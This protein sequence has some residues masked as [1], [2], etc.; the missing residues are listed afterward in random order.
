MVWNIN[1]SLAECLSLR[2]FLRVK[3]PKCVPG[4]TAFF[5]KV[6]SRNQVSTIC[7]IF[8]FKMIYKFAVNLWRYNLTILSRRIWYYK[9]STWE[10]SLDSPHARDCLKT[11][12]RSLCK[13][14]ANRKLEARNLEGTG[15][16]FST[17]KV[18]KKII[19]FFSTNMVIF[20]NVNL[21]RKFSFFNWISVERRYLSK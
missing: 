8:E 15:A 9:T 11:D 13:K 12:L 7:S 16:D 14:E 5:V 17:T 10:W 4:V 1:I 6:N 20:L 3:V 19:H 21:K 18:Q 2:S